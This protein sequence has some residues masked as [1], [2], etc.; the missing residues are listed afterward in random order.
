[1]DRDCVNFPLEI[2]Y[3][4]PGD[5][6]WP[7]GAPGARKL[8]DFL[9]DQKIPRWLRPHVPLVISQGQIIWVPGLR[10]AEPVKLTPGTRTLLEMQ[11]SPDN[12]HTRRI[13]EM[14]RICGQGAA[15]AKAGNRQG[16]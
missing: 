16:T 13:W 11:I 9:V 3:F 10:L 2:R 14:L 5:R 7:T 1:L 8:Q 15:G 4:Q 12:P 6:F